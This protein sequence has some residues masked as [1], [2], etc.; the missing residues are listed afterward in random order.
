MVG[1]AKVIDAACAGK[2]VEIRNVRRDLIARTVWTDGSQ[3]CNDDLGRIPRRALGRRRET[4]ELDPSIELV[5]RGA[6]GTVNLIGRK[7]DLCCVENEFL[8]QE[9][10]VLFELRL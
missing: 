3:R 10:R 1:I 4:C 2:T 5:E 7:A 6:L 8:R 9:A